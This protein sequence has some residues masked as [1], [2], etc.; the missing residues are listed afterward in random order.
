MS[1]PFERAV[2]TIES[3]RVVLSASNHLFLALKVFGYAFVGYL[4]VALALVAAIFIIG[5]L[6]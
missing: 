3:S 1:T 5:G 6:A 4:I 2:P